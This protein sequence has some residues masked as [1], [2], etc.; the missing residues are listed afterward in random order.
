MR[1]RITPLAVLFLAGLAA[2]AAGQAPPMKPEFQVNTYTTS[3]QYGYGV[4]MDKA[5]NFVVSW[6]SYGQDGDGYGVFGRRFDA[7]GGPAR[8]R[9]P[10]EPGNRL[11]PGVRRCRLGSAGQ[12][13]R[14]VADRTS[15]TATARESIARRFD[16]TGAAWATSSS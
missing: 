6:E 8:R 1:K 4:A 10:G 5:G 14:R 9:V 12:L 15:R 2:Q 16:K 7:A 13:C 11:R 3:D